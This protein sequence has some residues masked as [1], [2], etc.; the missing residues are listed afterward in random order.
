MALTERYV[1]TTGAGTHDGTSEA[2]A[3]TWA[4]MLTD[5]VSAAG[6]RYN[7]KK[8]ATYTRTTASDTTGAGTATNP[9][10]LRGY[11]TTPG[12]GNLGRT[13]S[14]GPLI[15]TNMP[16]ISY[17]T[18]RLTPGAFTIIESLEFTGA[19][20][21]QGPVLGG[22]NQVHIFSKYTNTVNGANGKGLNLN[23]GTSTL[24][25]GCDINQTGTTVGAGL[26]NTSTGCKIIGNRITS[27]SG[28]GIRITT[29]GDNTVFIMNTVYVC[30][31][32]A[33]NV[34][35]TSACG[36]FY[37]TFVGC[38]GD[39]IVCAAGLGALN[40]LWGNMI[41]DNGD[42]G[43]DFFSAASAVCAAY[44]RTRDN[45]SGKY[46]GATD[47]LAAT[48]YF[49]VTTDTG[50]SSTDYVAFG[51]Q[52]YNLV[53]TSAGV[54]AAFPAF[55]S[56]GAFQRTQTASLAPSPLISTLVQSAANGA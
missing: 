52:D 34:T 54:S 32:A 26:S 51:S 38:T 20:T 6:K 37:N 30:G 17:T 41:T 48:S 11:N 43:A 14:N 49:D 42:W 53:A 46:T 25:A 16:L 27:T 50:G 19:A 7:I 3:F 18:G 28:E 22:T 55:A 33:V 2:N 29:S 40:V 12:D 5:A 1:S 45:V 39:G 4:E 56:M 9:V 44:N 10:I 24:V 21:T 23:S 8:D 35:V 36:Y 13:S 15:T 31:T 47:W